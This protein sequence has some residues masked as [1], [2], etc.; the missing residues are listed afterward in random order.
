MGSFIENGFDAAVAKIYSIQSR[1][2]PSFVYTFV[3]H[4]LFVFIYL[5]KQ[6][7]YPIY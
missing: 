7:Y 1:E 5:K 3:S 4:S 2:E 6:R